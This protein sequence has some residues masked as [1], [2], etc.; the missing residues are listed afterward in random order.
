MADGPW[1]PDRTVGKTIQIQN[2][3]SIPCAISVTCRGQDI[4]VFD[5]NGDGTNIGLKVSWEGEDK[6]KLLPGQSQEI[7][8]I[9]HLPKEAD[10]TCQGD[11]WNV[12][13]TFHAEAA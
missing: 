10:N 3:G 4:P 13:F 9:V 12:T 11:I 7:L 5:A 6:R 8:L 2:V 1:W